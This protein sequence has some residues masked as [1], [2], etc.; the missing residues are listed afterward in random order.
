[1]CFSNVLLLL[2]WISLPQLL[3][4]FFQPFLSKT[5]NASNCGYSTHT[6]THSPYKSYSHFWVFSAG[7]MMEDL[8]HSLALSPILPVF[9]PP[10]H[11][12][13][14]LSNRILQP[15]MLQGNI[16]GDAL[17]DS[18]E[19]TFLTNWSKICTVMHC[20]FKK[21]RRLRNCRNL[22]VKEIRS[23]ELIKRAVIEI[24]SFTGRRFEDGPSVMA[25]LRVDRSGVRVWRRKFQQWSPKPTGNYR[26]SQLL[27]LHA[28]TIKNP[29]LNGITRWPHN[30]SS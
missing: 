13:S 26:G 6:H 27:N 23:K 22:K 20:I 21:T 12:P 4:M 19:V 24:D 8:A 29:A 18:V 16:D 11:G 7:I 14:G 2:R 25:K 28:K 10:A 15:R 1:M 17:H 9:D 3:L 5:I 30:M